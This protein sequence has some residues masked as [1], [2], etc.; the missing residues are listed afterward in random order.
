M[1]IG[2]GDLRKGVTIELD[3]EPYQVVEYSS[4]K[5]Q[6]RAPVVRLRLRELRTGRSVDRTFSGYDV[7]LNLASVE[8]RPAQY[9]YSD[10]AFYYFMDTRT[11][12]QY[13]LTREQLGDSY[14]YLKDQVELELVFFGEEPI[15]V[16][17]PTFVELEVTDTAPAHRGNTAQGGTK[18]ATLETGLSVNVPFFVNPGE[19]IRID[20]RTGEY[21][22]R[23][24]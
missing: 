7:K 8:Q 23:A 19:M 13:P 11:Y 24:D 18:P 12:E 9:L 1:V 20:T 22:E 14:L 10:D 16:E 4:H 2:V 21:L 6:Q 17:L 15:A 5:M 3:G